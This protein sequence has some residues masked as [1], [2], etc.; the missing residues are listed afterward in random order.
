LRVFFLC[1]SICTGALSSGPLAASVC[2]DA[3]NVAARETGVPQT[4]LQAVALAETGRQNS[5]QMKPWPWAINVSGRS[6]WFETEAVAKDFLRT[7]FPS[8]RPSVDIGCFQLNARWHGA[9]FPSLEA[10]LSPTENAFYAASFLSKLFEETGDWRSAVGKYHSRQSDLAA[11]YIAK[12]EALYQEHLAA[13]PVSA[14]EDVKSRPDSNVPKVSRPQF[15]L[16]GAS[17]PILTTYNAGRFT[18]GASK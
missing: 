16:R 15:S 1:L 13:G 3:I 6:H 18:L 8:G 7:S 4:I 17:G 10:M 2:D 5:G 14:S 9:A 11:G 12:V